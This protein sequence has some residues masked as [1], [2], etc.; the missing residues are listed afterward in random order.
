MKTVEIAT[1]VVKTLQKA[2]HIAYFAG[3]W[4]RDFLL[5]HPSDDIDIAT[6]AGIEEIAA[7]FPKTIPIGA[8]FG[9]IL[10]VEEG[11]SFEVAT[12]RKENE[13][14][15]GRRPTRIERATPEEDA[16]RRDFTINGLFFDPLTKE[17]F[18]YVGGQDD[19]KKGI[20]RAI[21]DPHQRFLEDRLRM[22]RAARYATRFTFPI[23]CDTE[24][25][26][27]FHAKSLL[28]AVAIERIWQELQK[29][30]KFGHLDQSL[31]LLHQLELLGVI[32]P[33]LKSTSLIELKKTVD[34][35]AKLPKDSP[36]IAKL[37]FLFPNFS[38]EEQL[39]LCN[40][41]KLSRQEK[42][43]VEFLHTSQNLLR[44]PLEWQKKL[45]NIEWAYF[46]AHPSSFLSLEICK[47]Q[48]EESSFLLFHQEKR[49]H[50]SHFIER[51]QKKD[52]LIKAADL[53]KEGVL[54]GVQMG[55]LLKE[56]EKISINEE[57]EDKIEILQRLKKK[58]QGLATDS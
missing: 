48:K 11:H 57:I 34:L 53:Q 10:V 2:G 14:I 32:F 31:L 47:V 40:Y 9:I 36:L 8:A 5:K 3:G 30:S 46:Y 16:Q 33:S 29:M 54:P 18:D 44:M 6:S 21:G 19:L 22:M 56:A 23:E 1:K 45:E 42:E 51:I 38:L 25:A 28:P 20:I 26:I 7:L 24:Q 50:L 52:P 12:F 43:L 41:L 39:N 58:D 37:L 17:I 15:D 13:Y 27:L 4:V 35:I 55:K 49:A